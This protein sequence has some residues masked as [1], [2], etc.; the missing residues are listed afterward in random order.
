MQFPTENGGLSS[1]KFEIPLQPVRALY[2][3]NQT[4]GMLSLVY[5]PVFL[6]CFPISFNSKCLYIYSIHNHNLP[7]AF[8]NHFLPTAIVHSR[9]TR[10]RSNLYTM[11]CRT[12]VRRFSVKLAGPRLWSSVDIDIRSKHAIN[13]FKQA[14]R[15]HL[16][17]RYQLSMSL[18]HTHYLSL[19]LQSFLLY[20][21]PVPS[22]LLYL[23]GLL[24]TIQ[25]QCIILLVN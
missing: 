19:I 25:F 14:Y 1:D 13:A 15:N 4:T 7:I 10:G 9:N 2:C 24:L 12:N 16:L 3:L 20:L 21:V 5:F 8:D 23:S 11:S 6:I 18:Y 17:D 22:I